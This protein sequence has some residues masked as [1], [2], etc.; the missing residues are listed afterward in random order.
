MSRDL[1]AAN[2]EPDSTS[3]ED[4]AA[5]F[6]AAVQHHQAGRLAHAAAGYRQ[7]IAA[8]PDFAPAHANLGV[9]LQAQGAHAEAAAA[10]REAIRLK[11][12]FAEAHF[13]LGTVLDAAARPDEAATA[14]RAA[15]AANPRLVEAHANLSNV[16]S[17]QGRL[18]EAVTWLRQA[19]AL[20]PNR[21]GLH[22]N[23]GNALKDRGALE[24]AAAAF[25][26]AI[27]LKPDHADAHANLAIV[28][29]N[30]GRIDEADAAF[31]HALGLAPDNADTRSNW[32]FCLNYKTDVSAEQVFAAHRDWDTRHGTSARRMV[33]TN[34]RTPTRR[35][36]IG[37]VSPDFRMHSV[38]YFLEP[39]LKAH[40]R[41]AVEVT[42]YADV[43]RPDAV[44]ARLQTLADRWVSTVGMS[45]A[46]LAA[47][48]QADGIDILIDC[49]GHTAH[50]RLQVF[51][52][53]PAPVQATWLGY[54]NTT[55]LSAIDYRLVD[56]VTDPPGADALASERL[57]RLP[58]GFLC[59]AGASDAPE[60]APPPCLTG[61]PV[62]FGSF[63]NPAKLSPRRSTPGPRCS[64]GC[65]TRAC[66]SRANPSATRRRAICT[67]PASPSAASRP[68]A[69]NSPAGRRQARIISRSMS[70]SISRSTR[71]PT[72]APRPPAK[73]SGWACRWSRSVASAMAAASAPA[74]SPGSA[75]TTGLPIRL[76]IMW[77]APPRWPPIHRN[78]ALYAAACARVLPPRHCATVSLLPRTSKSHIGRCGRRGARRRHE[79]I[80]TE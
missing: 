41:A 9:A 77:R 17:A 8:K 45:D 56:A 5:L 21:P 25:R 27:G 2:A 78:C 23:L 4:P 48:I 6:V 16:L 66:C 15:I 24:E 64:R 12:D 59:Y 28:L 57:I 47:R 71:F 80:L 18:D 54:P 33:H 72:T 76:T 36:K 52:R 37:Y 40:D 65:R 70:A 51:A 58:G 35:L 60:P 30:Q 39:L 22:Y 79:I 44:T 69:W 19:T 3:G 42:C 73:R 26:A 32:L 11:P 63:N 31:R 10:L 50:N 1:R 34:D 7:I 62:T 49:A 67:S 38:A 46:A 20:E 75:P 68:S 29:M 61:G 53:K 74:C 43:A 13:N 14:Y 55:G